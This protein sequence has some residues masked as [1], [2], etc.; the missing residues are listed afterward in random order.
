MN[1]HTPTEGHNFLC[2][3]KSESALRKGEIAAAEDRK[4]RGT[5]LSCQPEQV[6]TRAQGRDCGWKSFCQRGLGS[7]G[8]WPVNKTEVSKE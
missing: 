1:N 6:L 4:E 7:E 3:F 8:C 2:Q 5:Y